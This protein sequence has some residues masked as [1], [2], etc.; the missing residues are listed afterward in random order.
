MGMLVKRSGASIGIGLSIG[1]F[2]LYYM[3]LIGGESAGDRMILAP[4]LAMWLPNFVFGI[5]GSILIIYAN[6]R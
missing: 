1:F 4:W 6:R 3:F 2:A 5:P